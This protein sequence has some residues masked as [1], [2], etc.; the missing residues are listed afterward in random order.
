MMLTVPEVAQRL[1][2]STYY[3]RS[4]VHRYEQGQ[5]GGL[6]AL[7]L[8]KRQMLIE[9]KD[10]AAFIEAKKGGPLGARGHLIGG[11]ND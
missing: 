11:Q 6:P 10:L 4:L 1:R 2:S 9:E 7:R 3:V 8:A 5:E